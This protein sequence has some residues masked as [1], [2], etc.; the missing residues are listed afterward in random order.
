MLY[1]YIGYNWFVSGYKMIEQTYK[2]VKIPFSEIETWLR[3]KYSLPSTLADVRLEEK[4]IL[5][6]FIDNETSLISIISDKNKKMATKRRSPKKRNRMKTRGW[7]AVARIINSK[8][9]KCTIYKP[10]VDALEKPETSYEEKKELVEK[11][12]R[13]NKNKPSDESIIY[14][15]EN[16]LEYLKQGKINTGGI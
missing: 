13:A 16:T 5:F 14:Y 1:T 11:I 15:L 10:F 7:I 3:A 2:I 8:G 12:L 6:S 4:M 9:Q